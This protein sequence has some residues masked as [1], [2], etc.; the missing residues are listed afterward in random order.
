MFANLFA[1]FTT[2]AILVGLVVFGLMGYLLVRY[3]ARKGEA[4]P[5]DAPRL[6]KMPVPRG[7]IRTTIVS[8]GLSSI[9][10][11]VLI[12]GTL[13]VTNTINTIPADCNSPPA[14]HGDCLYIYVT[15]FRFGWDFKYLNGKTLTDNL[16]IPVGRTVVLQVTSKDVFHS[17]GIDAFRAK[18]DALP[19]LT[20]SLWFI[21][22]SQGS[23]LARCFELCG[24]GH[25]F[26]TAKVS[27]VSG[28]SFS[29]FC[30][31]SGC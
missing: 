21:P 13:A 15:A 23:Y 16:T 8:V 1:T 4:D 25:A 18:K 3:R 20:N 24:T 2:L 11:G 10:L 28:A 17:F 30:S 29:G 6:G 7:H 27:V 22:K 5:E 26:M 9:I 14:P 31:S 19:G 12:F